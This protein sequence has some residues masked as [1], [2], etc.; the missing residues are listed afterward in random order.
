MIMIAP[1]YWGVDGT[2]TVFNKYYLDS[3][4]HIVN[5]KTNK[6]MSYVQD[7]R[8]YYSCSLVDNVGKRR[9]IRIVR[10][11]ASTHHGKP[12]SLEHTADHI[13]RIKSDD[14]IDNIRW[15]TLPEQ[16][17][18]QDRPKT[19]NS[20]Q[21]IVKDG[22]E[23]TIKE[24][25]E[26]L[27]GT[28]NPNNLDYTENMI[29][30]YTRQKKLGFDYKEYPDLL[31][32][33]WKEIVGSKTKTGHWEISNMNRVKWITS[34]TKNVLSGERICLMNGYPSIKFN[35][36]SW[37]C[38]I[39]SYKAFFPEEY[40]NKK[41]NE[42]V[43]H[44]DDDRKDFRPQKLRLGTRSDNGKDAYDNGK[45]NTRVKCAS[46]INEF[47]EKEHESQAEAARYLKNIGFNKA[48]DSGIRTAIK[49]KKIRYK[50]TWK[51][52]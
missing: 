51:L 31:N 50:R 49:K 45:L 2:L 38:H 10:M 36:R 15:A 26:Y 1:E 9:G 14:H 30:K 35:G 22:V 46:Y 29:K 6:R 43:L 7:K 39:L 8:G 4:D 12:P 5:K 25:V 3:S 20:S 19:N 33:E 13:N 28:K 17:I 40:A 52:V 37:M 32:E 27:K 21:I 24:W 18:N 42:M 34:Y 47:F 11:L 23:K 41:L 48:S 16:R 44:E